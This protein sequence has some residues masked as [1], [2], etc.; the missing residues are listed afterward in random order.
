MTI[1]A[2]VMLVYND[3]G[4]VGCEFYDMDRASFDRLSQ[5]IN[6]LYSR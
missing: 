5:L 1:E 3:E 4:R 2:A 6:Q